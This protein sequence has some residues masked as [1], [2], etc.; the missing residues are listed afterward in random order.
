MKSAKLFG[1]EVVGLRGFQIGR[2][3]GINFDESSWSIASL[4]VRL[5]RR[6][7]EEFRMRRV[8]V[9]TKIEVGVRSISAVGDRVILSVSKT[10]LRR[11]VSVSPKAPNRGPLRR[12]RPRPPLPEPRGPET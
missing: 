8:L 11:M 1:K 6:V 5:F 3:V 2:V 4:D 10:D 9:R 12:G 7:A